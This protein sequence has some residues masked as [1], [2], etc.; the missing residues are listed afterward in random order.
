MEKGPLACKLPSYPLTPS[1]PE[2]KKDKGICKD[3]PEVIISPRDGSLA[4]HRGIN[5][6]YGVHT[7]NHLEETGP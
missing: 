2:S 5:Q 7:H 1:H 6:H 4:P 3:H